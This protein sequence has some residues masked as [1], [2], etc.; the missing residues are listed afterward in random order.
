MEPYDDRICKHT[1]RTDK[2]MLQCK[3]HPE[4]LWQ[5]KNIDYV[6]ARTIFFRG[7]QGKHPMENPLAKVIGV[8]PGDAWEMYVDDRW[9]TLTLTKERLA[10]ETIKAVHAHDNFVAVGWAIECLCPVRDLRLCCEECNDG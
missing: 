9:V 4:L 10:K 3:N 5:T 8:K 6:G 1:D 7:A 2:V